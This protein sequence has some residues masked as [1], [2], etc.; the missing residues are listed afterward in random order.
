MFPPVCLP[1][2]F[3]IPNFCAQASESSSLSSKIEKS[4]LATNFLQ[5]CDELSGISE[6]LDKPGAGP[7]KSS[8]LAPLECRRRPIC[9][10][11]PRHKNGPAPR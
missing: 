2:K 5:D 8:G 7:K 9:G 4:V 10:A 1:Q 6:Q 3:G 11:G